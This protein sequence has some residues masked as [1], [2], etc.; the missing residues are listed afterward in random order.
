M[1]RGYGIYPSQKRFDKILSLLHKAVYVGTAMFEKVSN[2]IALQSKYTR[3]QAKVKNK[4]YSLRKCSGTILRTS[5]YVHILYILHKQKLNQSGKHFNQIK[6]R[7]W[8][9]GVDPKLLSSKW[10]EEAIDDVSHV[11]ATWRRHVRTRP[12]ILSPTAVENTSSKS[13]TMKMRDKKH[14]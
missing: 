12:E 10:T 6:H 5:K 2:A 9:I 14:Q 11:K 13:D 3:R 8:S 7:Y 4:S 1:F